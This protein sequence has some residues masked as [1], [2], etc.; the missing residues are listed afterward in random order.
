LDERVAVAMRVELGS[1]IIA[2]HEVTWLTTQNAWH[3]AD[4]RKQTNN[5]P[6]RF[7]SVVIIS[8][9]F[10]FVN[11]WSCHIDKTQYMLGIQSRIID[12]CVR[13]LERR[14]VKLILE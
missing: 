13:Q 9:N 3:I 1:M 10:C 14:F 11:Y 5:V 8:L 7:R 6:A 2:N 12:G 4:T